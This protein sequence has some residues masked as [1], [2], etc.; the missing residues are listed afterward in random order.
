MTMKMTNSNK[1]MEEAFIQKQA[2]VIAESKYLTPEEKIA[3][4]K[5]LEDKE[6]RNN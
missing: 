3:I 6:M 4:L 1:Y 2:R 5:F